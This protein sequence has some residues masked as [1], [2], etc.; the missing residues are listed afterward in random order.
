[1]AL[2]DQIIK[3]IVVGFQRSIF[4]RSLDGFSL[5]SFTLKVKILVFIILLW[6]TIQ[7][8]SHDVH[9]FVFVLV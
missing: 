9:K 5:D 7:I 2:D 8:S 6:E 3:F 4:W 1:M